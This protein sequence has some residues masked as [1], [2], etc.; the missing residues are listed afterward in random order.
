M[1][2]RHHLN[3]CLFLAIF[4]SNFHLLT[5]SLAQTV[6]ET[7]ANTLK[8]FSLEM[9]TPKTCAVACIKD[10]SP[11]QKQQFIS[12]ID[13]EYTVHW[14]VDNLPVGRYVSTEDKSTI[15]TRGFA[16]GFKQPANKK[17]G[18]PRPFRCL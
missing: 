12:A 18:V 4:N 6:P 9:R 11:K 7:N 1:T 3:L 2:L 10:L 14:I 17:V 13:E 16:V 8:V 15:F 5:K